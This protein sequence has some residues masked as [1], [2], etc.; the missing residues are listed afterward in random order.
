[1]SVISNS[2]PLLAIWFPSLTP[3]WVALYSIMSS[4]LNPPSSSSNRFL[5]TLDWMFFLHS[6]IL[7][8]SQLTNKYLWKYWH[9]KKER[10]RINEMC[11]MRSSWRNLK[12][13]IVA[14]CNL[15]KFSGMALDCWPWHHM[16]H[17]FVMHGESYEMSMSI[18]KDWDVYVMDVL[19]DILVLVNI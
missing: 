3:F 13:Y 16:S 6:S 4:I 15:V 1:M 10:V 7:W 9:C 8:S 17:S 5:L 18:V 2:L 19:C 11:K 12:F 14:T